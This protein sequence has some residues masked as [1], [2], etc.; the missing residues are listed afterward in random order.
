MWTAGK[1]AEDEEVHLLLVDRMFAELDL[2]LMIGSLAGTAAL[3]LVF[4]EEVWIEGSNIPEILYRLMAMLAAAETGLCLLFILAIVR[5]LKNRSF[6][7]RSLILAA[8]KFCWKLAVTVVLWAWN[9]TKRIFKWAVITFKRVWHAL[10]DAKDTIVSGLF[11]NYKTRNVILL[12]L[13]YSAALFIL[14]MMFGVLIDYGEGF[15]AF[16]CALALFGVSVAFLIKRVEGFESI[17]RGIARIRSGELDYKIADCPAGVMRTI[18]EDMNYIGEGLS[19]ALANEVKA[20]RMKSELITN[21]SHDLKTPLTSIINYADLLCQEEL[22]PEEANDYAA[23]IKQKSQRLKNLTAD[24]FDIS[25][26]QSGTETI[27][28][29][30]S[31]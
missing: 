9:L 29:E 1:Q 30:K 11:R 7:Q 27:E 28:R 3:F 26:V 31:T 8:V 18:A 15:F 6:V 25:K 10:V 21:V 19:K 16:L 5:N 24:L 14:A 20:E 2:G 12:F 23:I 13:V 22:K 17:C 4:C